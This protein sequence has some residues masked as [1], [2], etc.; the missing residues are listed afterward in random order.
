MLVSSKRRG[1]IPD[2]ASPW[3]LLLLAGNAS[4]FYKLNCFFSDSAKKKIFRNS[5]ISGFQ[6]FRHFLLFDCLRI[7]QVFRHKTGGRKA[8]FGQKY[9]S[10]KYPP[11]KGNFPPILNFKIY[12]LC[13]QGLGHLGG[14][15]GQGSCGVG[16]LRSASEASRENLQNWAVFSVKNLHFQGNWSVHIT[17][18][19]E[20]TSRAKRSE[21]ILRNWTVLG[22]KN[23]HLQENWTHY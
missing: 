3:A 6:C 14:G 4:N 9:Y 7:Y 18:M 10:L 13:N 5:K 20:N 16:P 1:S 21:K 19:T 22:V 11:K 15:G 23:L 2:G 12:T 17:I 8:L